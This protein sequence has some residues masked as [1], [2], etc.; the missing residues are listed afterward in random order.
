MQLID[1]SVSDLVVIQTRVMIRGFGNIADCGIMRH[2]RAL[3]SECSSPIC[4]PR[5]YKIGY[6]SKLTQ[7]VGLNH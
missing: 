3:C 1:L 4:V 7:E 6:K 5:T 2:C